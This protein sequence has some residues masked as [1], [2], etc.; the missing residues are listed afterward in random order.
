MCTPQ[1]LALKLYSDPR[2][3][4]EEVHF[5]GDTKD[6]VDLSQ[7]AKQHTILSCL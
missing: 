2:F 7:N 3:S 5:R 6:A 4:A 1:I